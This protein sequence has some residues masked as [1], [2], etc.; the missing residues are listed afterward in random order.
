MPFPRD[1]IFEA[2]ALL[3]RF[4]SQ[5][6]FDR[7]ILGWGL[8]ELDQR[9]GSVERRFLGLFRLVRD[10][11]DRRY[12]EQPIGDLIVG[13]A[14]TH[15][16]GRDHGFQPQQEDEH[17]G[18]FRRA[19]Q[20]AGYVLEDGELRRQ[21]PEALDLPAAADDVRVL[22]Q[23]HGFVTAEGH[24]DQTIENHARGNW[25]AANGQAR[26]FIEGLLDEIALR[27]DPNAPAGAQEGEARRERLANLQPPFLSPAL[28][29]WG[30]Q[31]K[32]LVNGVMKRLHP[33]GAHPG[34]SD[35]EDS[36]FRLHLVLLLGRLFLRRFDGRV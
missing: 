14:L 17:I 25:A 26:N 24:Y 32:N 21:L 5:A 30:N 6:S 15:L 3:P 9:D 22:L 2:C 35:E 36:T 12:E 33:Q 7:L 13:E 19:L 10:D 27:L 23:R 28:N 16:A 31:G 11:P 29:E 20:R 1:V 34:L 18:R 4:H 8:D